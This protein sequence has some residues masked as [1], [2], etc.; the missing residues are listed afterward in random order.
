[1]KKITDDE[2]EVIIKTKYDELDCGLMSTGCFFE[3]E[4]GK[5]IRDE[6]EKRNRWIPVTERLPTDDRFAVADFAQEALRDYIMIRV[7][8]SAQN[9]DPLIVNYFVTGFIIG[10]MSD[11]TIY[12]VVKRYAKKIGCNNITPHSM[13]A[14]VCTKLL[15]DGH[16]NYD[17]MDFSR[18]SSVSMLEKYYKRSKEVKDS[19]IYR[20][21]FCYI[22]PLFSYL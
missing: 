9:D 6:I 5:F 13:R 12:R 16:L 15:N 14:S 10:A 18:H 3:A 20:L 21:K 7:N 17:I 19:V 8:E 2:I 4:G 11:S 1:M 22:L